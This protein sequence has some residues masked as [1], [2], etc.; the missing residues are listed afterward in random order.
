[1]D[2]P[3][4]D[5]PTSPRSPITPYLRPHRSRAAE[6][7]GFVALTGTSIAFILYHF[8]ALLPDSVIRNLGVEWYPSREWALL[9]PAYSVVLILLTYFSY[10]AL[11]LSATPS[12]SD[13]RTITDSYAHVPAQGQ[14]NPYLRQADPDALPEL[15]DIPIGLVN[16]VLFRPDR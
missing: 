15:Y 10:W 3:D 8:W 11:A 14:P 2:V 6:F 1:M 9:I 5:L 12:F 16:R 4:P 13:L 7:Y